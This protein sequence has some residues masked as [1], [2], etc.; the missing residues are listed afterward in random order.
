MRQ[1]EAKKWMRAGRALSS[2]NRVKLRRVYR[3]GSGFV[4]HDW[5][6]S[7]T[8]LNGQIVDQIAETMSF[9]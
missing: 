6:P 3:S 9:L 5:M 7:L 1:E 4:L 2:K 8:S